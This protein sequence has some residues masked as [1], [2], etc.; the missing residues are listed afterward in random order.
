MDTPE[1]PL[2]SVIIPTRN[3]PELFSRALE[4]VLRQS[5]R[6]IE[7]LVVNDGSADEF[8]SAYKAM[9]QASDPRVRW[10]YQPQRANGHG[11]SYSINTGAQ[12]AQGQYLCLLDDDDSWEDVEH[13]ARACDV[14]TAADGRVDAY[15]SNQTA[16]RADGSAVTSHLWVSS[17]AGKLS[18][19]AAGV[20]GTHKVTAVFLL[21]CNGFPHLNCSIIR[22]EL[23]LAIGGMDE[24]IRYECEVDLYLRTLDAASHIVYN[25]AFIARHNIPDAVAK[26][27][28]STGVSVIQKR[29][30]QIIVYQKNLIRAP[31]QPIRD[32]CIKKLAMLNKALCA[33]FMASREFDI[34]ATHARV[35]LAWKWSARWWVYSVYLSARAAIRR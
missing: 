3:R 26:T 16:Y 32:N 29:R 14:I 10:Y 25:P 11:P 28:V 30:S 12:A 17:L 22:R 2:F 18:A 35:A 7:V 20:H 33:D 4:S 6:N 34:A 5:F 8:L 9:E 19:E 24:G 15:Y 23:Y 31:S 1:M 27:S 21:G 13:L